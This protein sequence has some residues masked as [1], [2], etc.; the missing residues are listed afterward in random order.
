M[1][2]NVPY[3]EH[4]FLKMK[5]EL[6]AKS[7]SFNEIEEILNVSKRNL[8]NLVNTDYGLQQYMISTTAKHRDEMQHLQN[9][10]NSTQQDYEN[11]SSY[12]YKEW[13]RRIM[14]IQERRKVIDNTRA[15]VLSQ[16]VNLVSLRKSNYCLKKAIINQGAMRKEADTKYTIL[17]RQIVQI[18]NL[19]TKNISIQNHIKLN[20]VTANQARQDYETIIETKSRSAE[21][22]KSE[23]ETLA[24]ENVSASI[25]YERLKSANVEAESKQ[26][27]SSSALDDD[28]MPM[29]FENDL[30]IKTEELNNL[31]ENEFSVTHRL[32]QVNEAIKD[33]QKM[34]DK[35]INTKNELLTAKGVTKSPNCNASFY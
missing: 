1:N 27:N 33:Y 10:L 34:Q 3:D 30:Q 14:Q 25:K 5:D 35:W 9:K 15:E 28:N 12:Q 16:N 32:H 26:T 17:K 2:A 7:H 19:N 4:K 31:K 22:L 20:L 29:L 6:L 18:E 11:K 21:I 8:D 13:D 24:K 23:N